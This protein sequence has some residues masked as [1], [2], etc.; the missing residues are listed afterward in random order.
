MAEIPHWIVP[1]VERSWSWE[2]VPALAPLAR[3]EDGSPPEQETLLRAA[4][5]DEALHVRFD[6]TDRDAWAT[7]R[8][9]DAKLYEEEVIE[10]FLA[11]GEPDP[12]SY[13]ELEVNPL[14]ALF[15]AVIHNPTGLRRDMVIDTSWDC[16]G[17]AWEAGRGEL[18]QDWWAALSLPWRGLGQEGEV[19]TLWRANFYRIERPRDGEIEWTAASPTLIRPAEFHRPSKFGRLELGPGRI[20]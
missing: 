4:W 11:P 1:R 7:L 5:D 3:T 12:T 18:R 6:C 20:R 17:I 10:I 15:D 9:H 14:G 16:A 19:P 2:E 13:F 8:E